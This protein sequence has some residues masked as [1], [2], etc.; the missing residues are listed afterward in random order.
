[1]DYK[2]LWRQLKTEVRDLSNLEEEQRISPGHRRRAYAYQVLDIMNFL[3]EE[4]NRASQELTHRQV[5]K[6]L[7]HVPTE[8]IIS[9]GTEF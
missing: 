7:R 1:M 5:G 8:R 3:E 2:R 6:T 9:H 4:E